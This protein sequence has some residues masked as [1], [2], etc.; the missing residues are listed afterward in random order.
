MSTAQDDF[1]LTREPLHTRSIE[2]TGY[3]RSDGLYEVE[4]SL[5]DTKPFDFKPISG[6]RVVGAGQPIHHLG[7]RIVF[8]DC[9]TVR[10]V[11]AVADATPYADCAAG[12]STL[13]SLI[14]LSMTKG[15]SAETRKRLSGAASCVHLAGLMGPMAATAFQT[16]VVLRLRAAEATGAHKPNVDSCIAYSR[17]GELMRTRYPAFYIAKAEAN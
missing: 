17:H 9:M 1:G 2:I 13:K 11:I 5:K 14:G 7:V 15:W 12:P 16:M 10:D 6:D 3:R 8:D 4:G